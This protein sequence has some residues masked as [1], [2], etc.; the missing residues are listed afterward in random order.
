MSTGPGGAC[1]PLPH[2]KL[3]QQTVDMLA[4]KCPH[5]D[6]FRVS[7]LYESTVGTEREGKLNSKREW[8]PESATVA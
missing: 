2:L 7:Q 8:S 3:K 6:K 1:A 4:N 5:V